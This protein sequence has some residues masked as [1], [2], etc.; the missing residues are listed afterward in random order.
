L[1]PYIIAWALK[2]FW[3]SLSVRSWAEPFADASLI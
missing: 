1:R 3:M 2:Y